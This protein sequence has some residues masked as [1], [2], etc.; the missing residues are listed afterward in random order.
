V[1]LDEGPERLRVVRDAQV[2]ELVHDDVV[3][4]VGW[5]QHEPPVEGECAAG[6]ARAPQ[7]PL[8]ADPDPPVG[9]AELIGLALGHGRDNRPCAIARV[10]LADGKPLEPEPRYLAPPSFLD[11]QAPLGEH[12]LHVLAG[13]RARHGESR[14]PAPRHLEAPPPGARRSPY[15]DRLHPGETNSSP[16]QG[17]ENAKS[18]KETRGADVA[19]KADFTEEEWKTMQKGVTGAGM[20]VSASDADFTDSFGEASALAKYLAQQQQ[21]SGSALIRDLAHMHSTG[22]GFTASREKAE[23]ETLDSLRSAIATLQMKAP[24]DLAAYQE[25]V[26]GIAE[27]VASAKSGVKPVETEAITKIKEAL[28]AAQ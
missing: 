9:D 4:D 13:G 17:C 25:L 1:S 28:A 2:A 12:T 7:C 14:R 6:G 23:T 26:I 3:D 21:N 11:P 5:S 8:A 16:G 27:H 20:L 19:T 10:R 24:D 15:L 18:G 22:F